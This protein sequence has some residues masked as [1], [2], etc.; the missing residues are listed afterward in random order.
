[1][2][3]L[4][5]EKIRKP[6]SGYLMLFVSLAI[7]AMAILFFTTPG[8]EAGGVVLLVVFILLSKGLL[9]V[10]PNTAKVFLLF[11]AYRGSVRTSG[12]YWVNPFYGRTTLS[13]RAR[14]FES[15]QLKVNDKMGNPVLISVILVW[16]VKDTYRASFDVDDY[17]KFVK[18][19]TDAAVRK[20]AASYPYD[21]FEDERAGITLSTDFNEV[22]STLER[23]TTERLDIAGIEVVE[24]RITHLAYAPEIASAMLRRQQAS[25]VVAARHKI[26]E[27]AVG[28]VES[29]LHLLSTKQII[30]LD[31][32][33]KAAM[34]SNL[35][36]VL[37]GDRDTQP[38]VNTGTLNH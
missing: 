4:S 18:V 21:H 33:K 12:L 3:A 14:N 13:M 10:Q 5:S 19:Q 2:S 22:N 27:G 7:L 11:G 36:V 9:V 16:K 15:E 37:C 23:E 35:M 25:A 31:E 32:E 1:M 6:P 28:M 38:V 24:A 34:V 30:E 29:A 20:L 26:V 8:L 17:A